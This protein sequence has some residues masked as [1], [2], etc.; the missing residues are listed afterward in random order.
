MSHPTHPSTGPLRARLAS[1]RREVRLWHATEGA[2]RLALALL[3]LCALS[4]A[5][6]WSWRLDRPQRAICLA[7]AL[8]A[9][10]VIAFRRLISPLSRSLSDEAL[11]ARVEAAH[12][13]PDGSAGEVLTA[14]ELERALSRDPSYAR[15]RGLAPDLVRAAIEAGARRAQALDFHSVIDRRAMLRSAT[16]LCIALGLFL[17]ISR[18]AQEPESGL[19]LRIWFDRNVLL[20]DAQWPQD[21]ELTIEGLADGVVRVPR[22]DDW[23]PVVRARGD[24]PAEVRIEYRPLASRSLT[25]Q[26]TQRG[27]R[28]FHA[29]FRNVLQPFRFRVSGGDAATP[30]IEGVLVER[31][32]IDAFELTVTPPAY[33]G[34]APRRV[35]AYQ[36][37]TREAGAS[38]AGRK[39][40]AAA[41]EAS[42]ATG[43]EEEVVAGSS[44]VDALKGSAIALRGRS[45]QALA[46]AS[47]KIGKESRAL[48]LSDEGLGFEATVPAD[49]LAAGAY[50]V[51]LV[52][53]RGLKPRQSTRFTLKLISDR[54]P[55]IR[56][57]L[58]GIGSMVVPGAR[59]PMEAQ[60]TDDFQVT[61]VRLAHEVRGESES[62]PPIK[63]V[64]P[65]PELAAGLPAAS[66]AK[67]VG[68]ELAALKPAVGQ[69]VSWRIEAVDNDALSGPQTG[70]GPL[71]FARVVTEQDL[72][73]ELLKRE[74]EQRQEFERLLR[75]QAELIAETQGLQPTLAAAGELG[76][77]LREGLLRMNKRQRL[78]AVRSRVIAEQ[79]DAIRLEVENNRLEEADGP[80]HQR[81]RDRI[82]KPLDAL[83]RRLVPTAADALDTLRR[84][85]PA[86]RAA[87][88][89]AALEAQREVERV[90]RDI[91]KHMVKWEGYQ[92]AVNLALEV[93]AAQQ[94]VSAE[95]RK[96]MLRKLEGIFGED[97]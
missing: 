61:Q 53:R 36:K 81:V 16:G 63:G 35:W 31:P 77:T 62:T 71:F 6:D 25:Q 28:G 68:F 70:Q 52:D 4:L 95:T 33:T 26:M 73:A 9:V 15:E 90:M 44:A 7:L 59:V 66:L 30:W 55:T 82:V 85:P 74:Q 83:A 41:S 3:I 29:V 92:E 48:T 69:F 8:A 18:L 76:E 10:A 96:A 78:V 57:R 51:E 24:V 19:F 89:Q 20:G 5:L 45:S 14:L 23:E 1:L 50:A 49:A 47:L 38:G 13:G 84:S 37:R 12:R 46:S 32:E 43:G 17:G 97:K 88:A 22:G 40:A 58:L 94:Q 67:T 2:G 60:V 86:G 34:Q 79:F 21:T 65:L 54:P 80:M 56:A 91:L 11:T 75:L 42:D 87:A 64:L 39:D 93:L 72:R 27:E